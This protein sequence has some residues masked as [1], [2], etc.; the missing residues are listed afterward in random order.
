VTDVGTTAVPWLVVAVAV[1]IGLVGV[2]AGRASR[3]WPT[4]TRHEVPS[5]AAPRDDWEALTI[6]EDPTDDAAPGR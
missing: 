4:G 2:V 3:T 6:G 5:R 1:L